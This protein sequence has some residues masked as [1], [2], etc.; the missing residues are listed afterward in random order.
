MNFR[1]GA[2]DLGVSALGSLGYGELWQRVFYRAFF[3]GGYEDHDEFPLQERQEVAKIRYAELIQPGIRLQLHYTLWITREF[4]IRSGAYFSGYGGLALLKYDK[5]SDTPRYRVDG[6]D[7]EIYNWRRL[8]Y[9]DGLPD[10][11]LFQSPSP[12]SIQTQSGITIAV[13]YQPQ[14]AL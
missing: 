7:R 9:G 10:K 6:I 5:S 8:P 1:I 13:I 11:S 4:A 12:H 14:P 3:F 2:G